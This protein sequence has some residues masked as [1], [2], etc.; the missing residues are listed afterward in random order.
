MTDGWTWFET[1]TP[2]GEAEDEVAKA[3]RACFATPAGRRVL[4][5]LRATFLERR[6]PPSVSDAELRH[7]EGQRS[8]VACVARLAEG[9]TP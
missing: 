6:L 4:D 8:V 2:S 5:H 1:P 3:F 7:V 9:N